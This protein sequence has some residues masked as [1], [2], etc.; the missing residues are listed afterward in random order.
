MITRVNSRSK[1]R[2]T[3]L[4]RVRHRR[5]SPYGFSGA[6]HDARNRLEEPVDVLFARAAPEREPERCLGFRGR[7]AES[8][9]DAAGRGRAGMAGRARR[10]RDPVEIERRDERFG[11]RAGKDRRRG[12][13]EA[14]AVRGVY[15]GA[16]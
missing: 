16:W 8:E 6:R 15:P 7:E 11:F 5:S 12:G 14:A 13:R 4:E 9:E 1:A 3:S 10:D 2:K